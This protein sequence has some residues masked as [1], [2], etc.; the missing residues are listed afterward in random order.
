MSSS[1]LRRE[2]RA[3]LSKFM[4]QHC[5][6]FFTFILHFIKLTV[7]AEDNYEIKQ[8]SCTHYIVI[9][10]KSPGQRIICFVIVL[11]QQSILKLLI[12]DVMHK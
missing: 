7:L 10:F 2:H 8:T 9:Y 1:H 5:K 11:K 3:S 12:S 4:W 6:K